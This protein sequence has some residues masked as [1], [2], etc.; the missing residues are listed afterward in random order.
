[1]ASS[2]LFSPVLNFLYPNLNSNLNPFPF[3]PME[4]KIRENNK[5]KGLCIC[6]GKVI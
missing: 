2:R 3:K 6:L 1:M 4:T 5:L